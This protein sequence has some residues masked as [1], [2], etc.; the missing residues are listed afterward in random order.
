MPQSLMG[1]GDS[2]HRCWLTACTQVPYK[3]FVKWPLLLVYHVLP[4]NLGVC[5][6][7]VTLCASELPANIVAE[8]IDLTQRQRMMPSRLGKRTVMCGLRVDSLLF[9][10]RYFSWMRSCHDDA[11]ASLA[12]PWSIC[13]GV[14]GVLLC[15]PASAALSDTI[16]P[17]VQVGYSYEDNLFRL[18]DGVAGDD[19]GGR[20]DTLRQTVVGLQ[21]LRPIGR[22][23]F[24]GTIRLSKVDF[25]H[26]TSLD[27]T[28]KDI[29]G[30]WLWQLGNHLEGSL[31]GT[32]SESLSPFSDFHSADRDLRTQRGEFF[33]G[34]WHFHPS[35]QVRTRLSRDEVEHD[36]LARRYL[37]ST[38][39]GTEVG[40]DYLAT[41][42]STVGLQALHQKARYPENQLF[43]GT[44]RD[45]AYT[46]DTVSLKV[47][48]KLNE[49]TDLQFLIGRARREH[50]TQGY[51]DSSGSNG[52]LVAHWSPLSTL[53]LT[54]TLSKSFEPFEGNVFSYSSSKS[55]S[56]AANWKL[57]PKISMDAQY[58]YAKR[59]FMGAA[60]SIL[61]LGAQDVTRVGSLGVNYQL[62]NN[63][64][65]S[66]SVFV[67]SRSTN[68]AY[69]S[70]YRAKGASIN[71]NAQF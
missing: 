63:I 26:Y 66:A 31:G 42:G 27:Y 37:N 1:K 19:G 17:F 12:R 39:D 69:S 29:A 8:L 48:W 5:C 61:L 22:Q 4:P 62:R 70:S 64:G 20:S 6:V 52:R 51:A 30:T 45:E 23:T 9:L 41:T 16:M 71:A 49:L 46:Q 40:F 13:F 7:A 11:P 59:D 10:P 50:P 47:F 58:R 3:L 14:A 15:A 57:L 38:L 68:T 34:K 55:G 56:L 60:S 18:P 43:T 67:D 35:W 32:Y 36:L 28:G 53:N 21:I 54:A 65:L 44:I 2:P 33:E 24:T 25:N